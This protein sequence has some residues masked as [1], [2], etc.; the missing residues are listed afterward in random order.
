[1]IIVVQAGVV[2]VDGEPRKVVTQDLVHPNVEQAEFDTEAGEGQLQYKKGV[3]FS[4]IDRDLEEEERQNVE[5]KAN[6][7]PILEKPVMKAFNYQRLP[8]KIYEMPPA[9]TELYN[10]WLNANNT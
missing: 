5:R 9:F 6:N 10:R 1:M 3:T 2:T 8:E 4:A 7:L